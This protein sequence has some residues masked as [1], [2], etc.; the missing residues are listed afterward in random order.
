MLYIFAGAPGSGKTTTARAL[1]GRLSAVL[2]NL[3]DHYREPHLC[4]D[5]SKA[6]E[7]EE[8]MATAIALAATGIYLEHGHSVILDDLRD[9]DA[10]VAARR[11]SGAR[12]V[13]LTAPA[14][15]IR[16]RL[17]AREA[18]F[19]DADAAIHRDGA[20]R[21]RP[22]IHGELRFDTSTTTTDTIVNHAAR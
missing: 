13:S 3:G 6:N 16:T 7:A 19:R 18:G 14:D 8:D 20:I 17:A 10:V 22:L 4:G 9:A 21:A 5:W 1:A 11:W 15:V 2:L 12:L